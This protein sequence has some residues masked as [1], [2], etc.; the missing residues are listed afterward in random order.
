MKYILL[1]FLALLFCPVFLLAANTIDINTASLQQLDALTGVGP[2]IAQRVIDG[3]PYATIDDLLRVKGIG[4][5]VLADIK[6]QGLAYVLQ[7]ESAPAP[8]PA[9]AYA[10]TTTVY[11]AGV[12]INE[13]LPSAEG[14]DEAGEWIELRNT[15]NAEI[16][17]FE[18]KLQDTEGGITTY[19]ISTKTLIAV[20]GYLTLSRPDTKITL[21]NDADGLRLLFADNTVVDSMQ[22]EGAKKGQSYNKTASGWAWSTMPTPGTKNTIAAL[23]ISLPKSKKSAIKVNVAA[24]NE[25]LQKTFNQSFDKEG[26][27]PSPWWLFLIALGITVVAG[28]ITTLLKI[29]INHVRP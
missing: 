7:T 2:V 1:L 14:T 21:N 20:N 26:A 17:L 25:P 6:D 10:P 11:P 4:E 24:I 18:W 28:I 23:A 15:S 8:T 9:L 16:D 19:T 13:V 29:Y 27:W 3:R 12:V 5:K 22:F